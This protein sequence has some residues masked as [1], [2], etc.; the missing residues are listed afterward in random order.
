M[1]WL[2]LRPVW[3]TESVASESTISLDKNLRVLIKK[4]TVSEETSLKEVEEINW[5]SSARQ[6]SA[7]KNFS[8]KLSRQETKGVHDCVAWTWS[9]I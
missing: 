7:R 5:P 6:P 4:V 2:M 3:A 8:R 9:W 1:I